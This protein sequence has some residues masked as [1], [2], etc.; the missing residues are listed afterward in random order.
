VAFCHPSHQGIE[1]YSRLKHRLLKCHDVLSWK[2]PTRTIDS[3]SWLH[4]GPPVIQTQYLKVLSKLELRHTA[5]GSLFSACHRLVKNFFLIP[6]PTPAGGI[7]TPFP[8]ALSLSQRAELSA[9]PPLPVRS[10]SRHEASPQLL[11][12]GLST[13]RDLICSSNLLSSKPFATRVAPWTLCNSFMS[14]HCGS[15]TC[16]Q[17]WRCGHSTEQSRATPPLSQWQPWAWGTPG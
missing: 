5:L 14:L 4:R 17:C 13:P 6:N 15:R 3:I 9:A 16:M 2:R 10:C 1:R 8:R 7:S 12:S 11:C